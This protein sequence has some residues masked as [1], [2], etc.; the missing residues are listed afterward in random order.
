MTSF[1]IG[2]GSNLRIFGSTQQQQYKELRTPTSKTKTM[3]SPFPV[4]HYSS[5]NCLDDAKP[6]CFNKVGCSSVSHLQ[7]SGRKVT[8]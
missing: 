3:L 4:C 8:S 6:G 1:Q 5:A 2:L 7:S